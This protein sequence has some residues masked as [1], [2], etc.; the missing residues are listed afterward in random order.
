[1]SPGRPR[2]LRREAQARTGA[3]WSRPRRT[4][5]SV[6]PGY[7]SAARRGAERTKPRDALPESP[8]LLRAPE[9]ALRP[10]F[11]APR[12]SPLALLA[13]P[14]FLGILA[15]RGSRTKPRAPGPSLRCLSP[16][17]RLS[18]PAQAA[19]EA[20]SAPAHAGVGRCPTSRACVVT[21]D[22]S[23]APS[24]CKAGF[25]TYRQRMGR[26][27]ARSQGQCSVTSEQARRP[28]EPTD[29]PSSPAAGPP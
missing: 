19:T 18:I 20:A 26:E 23:S 9:L 2:R 22:R 3:R 29:A 7:G 5:T 6:I 12:D 24:E 25:P 17:Q 14:A 27:A 1:M 21:R 28:T 13:A 15:P 10:T 8:R 16:L 4:G 11:S